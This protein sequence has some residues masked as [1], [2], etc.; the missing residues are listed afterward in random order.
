ME[1]GT[2][3]VAGRC[4]A[5]EQPR[6]SPEPHPQHPPPPGRLRPGPV[7]HAGLGEH[8]IELRMKTT[9]QA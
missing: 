1:A 2:A 9:S 6:Q 3:A 4:G 5:V 8:G 7:A